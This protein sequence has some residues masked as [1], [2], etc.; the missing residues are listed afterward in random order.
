MHLNLGRF[1]VVFSLTT[2]VYDGRDCVR[3]F[4]SQLSVVRDVR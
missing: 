4:K 2:E 1:M 3:T